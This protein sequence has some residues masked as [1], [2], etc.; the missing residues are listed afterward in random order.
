MLP[1][2]GDYYVQSPFQIYQPLNC[3]SFGEVQ[4]YLNMIILFYL[5]DTKDYFTQAI[6]M[7]EAV[8]LNERLIFLNYQFMW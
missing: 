8:F 1:Q 3:S 4:K 5:F 6:Q 7:R 2:C